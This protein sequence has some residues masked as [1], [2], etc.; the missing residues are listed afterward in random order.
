MACMLK[1]SRF[2]NGFADPLEGGRPG[3]SG[4]C[5]DVSSFGAWRRCEIGLSLDALPGTFTNGFLPEPRACFPTAGVYGGV[6]TLAG[7]FA[8]PGAW[9]AAGLGAED[10]SVYPEACRVC[11]RL[12]LIAPPSGENMRFPGRETS[13]VKPFAARLLDLRSRIP[14]ILVSRF[15]GLLANMESR[16][17]PPVSI[18]NG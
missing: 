7:P 18:L 13:S 9:L 1:V 6:R 2:E 17:E 5:I 11:S 10:G 4:A 16:L 3:L 12:R 8:E 15:A 14:C